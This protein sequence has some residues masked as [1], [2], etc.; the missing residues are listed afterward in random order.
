M[1]GLFGVALLLGSVRGDLEKFSL[2]L[3]TWGGLALT[4][5]AVTGGCLLMVGN[6]CMQTSLALGCPMT[7]LLPLQAALCVCIGTSLNYFLQP[8]RNDPSLLFSG[9]GSY[10]IAIVFSALAQVKH[11]SE[12]ARSSVDVLGDPAKGKRHQAGGKQ[13]PELEIIPLVSRDG[14]EERYSENS[15]A[16][17]DSEK[18]SG[19][20]A[21]TL[22]GAEGVVVLNQ[23]EE[24]PRQR[25]RRARLQVRRGLVI[26]VLGGFAFGGFAPAFNIAVND[27]FRWTNMGSN[28]D[29]SPLSVQT[30]NMIFSISFMASAVASQSMKLRAKHK[31]ESWIRII[32]H[33]YCSS[34]GVG[35]V[36]GGGERGSQSWGRT[37]AFLAGVICSVGNYLQFDGGK[38]A[39]FAAAD[40]VQAF[41]IVGTAWGVFLFD[42]YQGA[43][44]RIVLL[45]IKTY[46]FYILA[47][48]LIVCS[49]H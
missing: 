44:R 30:A 31:G 12:R 1:Y 33:I 38:R 34:G 8:E 47:V 29:S 40:V 2:P 46:V 43:S 48:V 19:S 26:G 10:L 15:C 23:E 39:G 21:G 24:D 49:T 6:A 28:G 14:K 5:T 27:E 13:I 25:A 9:V 4:L 18:D 45:L 36:G 7:T 22:L 16:L 32:T 35:G 11:E 42:D 37:F 20:G 17:S 3:S 41:P